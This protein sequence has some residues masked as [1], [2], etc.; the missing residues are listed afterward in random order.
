VQVIQVSDSTRNSRPVCNVPRRIG[1]HSACSPFSPRPHIIL[2][3][4]PALAARLLLRPSL[5]LLFLPARRRFLVTAFS[6]R[7]SLCGQK[8]VY[9]EL[10]RAATYYSHRSCTASSLADAWRPEPLVPRARVTVHQD[11]PQRAGM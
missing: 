3:S 10:H 9:P 5:G 1:L 11:D 4:C 8:K 7:Y 2:F 6:V